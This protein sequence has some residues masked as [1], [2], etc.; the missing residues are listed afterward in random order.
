MGGGKGGGEGKLPE[1]ERYLGGGIIDGRFDLPLVV[2]AAGSSSSSTS[3]R[4]SN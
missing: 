1:G 4:S 3:S 2:V